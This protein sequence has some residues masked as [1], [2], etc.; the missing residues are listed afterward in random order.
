M[1]EAAKFLDIRYVKVVRLSAQR[2]GR[3][4]PS[5]DIAATEFCYRPSRCMCVLHLNVGDGEV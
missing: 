3:L 2:T 1:L 4:Y 5:G